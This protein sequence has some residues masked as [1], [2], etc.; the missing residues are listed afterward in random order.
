MAQRAPA[1][2][3]CDL[4]ALLSEGPGLPYGRPVACFA[5]RGGNGARFGAQYGADALMRAGELR[6][7]TPH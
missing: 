6:S 2:I 5:R 3:Q 7:G 1:W 4:V